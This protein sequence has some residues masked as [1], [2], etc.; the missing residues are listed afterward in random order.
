MLGRLD[1]GRQ[2]T[3]M[4]VFL[5]CSCRTI[6]WYNFAVAIAEEE[7]HPRKPTHKARS[8]YSSMSKLAFE[9]PAVEKARKSFKID[10]P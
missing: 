2:P 8:S 6:Y 10:K 7:L 3:G 9:Y 5:G 4:P 1:A